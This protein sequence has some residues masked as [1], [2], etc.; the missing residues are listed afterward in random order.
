MAFVLPTFN[1]DYNLWH[2]P[3]VPPSDPVDAT[4]VCQLRGANHT[5]ACVNPTSALAAQAY[6]LF[7]PLED[8]RDQNNPNGSDF[9][10]IPAGSARYYQI[11]VVDDVA[12]GFTNE[13]RYAILNKYGF[14]PI[15]IP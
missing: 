2:G 1:L 13:H 3:S 4:G 9:I 12:K 5:A 15:P 11:M 6:A 8:V 10:E 14:W 7:G